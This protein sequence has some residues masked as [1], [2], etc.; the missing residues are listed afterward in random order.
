MPFAERHAPVV[1]FRDLSDRE[2]VVSFELHA[3]RVH[4]LYIP[5]HRLAVAAVRWFLHGPQS[6]AIF[7]GRGND[8][9]PRWRRAAGLCLAIFVVIGF[10]GSFG[11]WLGDFPS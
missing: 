2:G 9:F 8:H 11:N 5:M 1:D 10:G 7:I 6:Q 3:N 4:Y